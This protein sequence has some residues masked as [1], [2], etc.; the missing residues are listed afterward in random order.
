MESKTCGSGSGFVT[1]MFRAFPLAYLQVLSADWR[2]SFYEVHNEQL[3]RA[4]F[5]GYEAK[6][7]PHGAS[8]EV[9]AR[10]FADGRLGLRK[11]QRGM[12]G[13]THAKTFDMANAN[14][15]VEGGTGPEDVVISGWSFPQELV[16]S[17]P[18][19]N[20]RANHTE[21]AVL[22]ETVT[23]TTT[24]TST[25]QRTR[26]PSL[27]AID[28]SLPLHTEDRDALRVILA[29][30]TAVA[31]GY[32]RIDQRELEHILVTYCAAIRQQERN[33]AV[34]DYLKGR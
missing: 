15:T 7:V 4:L 16:I 26:Y 20:Y 2:F 11:L 6:G 14:V 21:P 1:L 24:A 34:D 19:L 29:T 32:D 10:G 9:L 28:S 33:S 3:W 5:A 30:V 27:L 12:S 8:L 17:G 25:T 22:R 31:G 13:A 23:T 18:V